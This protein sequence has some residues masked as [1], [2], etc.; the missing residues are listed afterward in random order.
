MRLLANENVPGIAVEALRADGH[1][2]A[3]VRTD[4]PG[5]ADPDVLARA[6]SEDRVLITFDKDFADLAFHQ[7][8][9]AT[10]GIILLRLVASSPEGIARFVVGV[11]KS[12]DDW[13]GHFSV[14]EIDRVR[15]VP[16][17]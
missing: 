8:L 6:V 14:I 1:D 2:V 3:W 9:R 5:S 4:A 17:P 13:A 16:L 7:R 12:R 15:M 11:L 10:P